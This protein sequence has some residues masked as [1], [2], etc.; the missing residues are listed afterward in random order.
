YWTSTNDCERLSATLSNPMKAITSCEYGVDHLK[1]Q[2]VEK[3]TP[4]DNELLVRVRAASINPVDGHL[5]RGNIL[6]RL[7]G[8]GLRKPKNTQ[9]GTDLAGVVEAVGKNVTDFKPGDEVF[10]AKNGAVAEYICAKA[11]RTVVSKPSNI[12]FEQA[13]SV[14]VAGL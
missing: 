4:A 6:M 12:T 9:F 8:G 14:A 1:L 10:G 2:E 5:I 11:D 13:G 7:L 3:P